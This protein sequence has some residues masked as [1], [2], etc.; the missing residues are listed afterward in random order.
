MSVYFGNELYH[1][2]VKGQHWGE[3]NY[4]NYDGT[5]TAA[6]KARYRNAF[7][8]KALG[9]KALG[10]V[11]SGNARIYEGISRLTGS[12]SAAKDAKN[13]RALQKDINKLSQRFQKEAN[14]KRDA[15]DYGGFKTAK[16]RS[17]IAKSIK[18]I[19]GTAIT[20]AIVNVGIQHF[21]TG[22]IDSSQ[23]VKAAAFS[24]GMSALNEVVGKHWK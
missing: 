11:A 16:R 3:R 6:G 19:S 14:A 9:Y 23:V 10:K 13:Q 24:G 18:N 7:S 8:A 4:Q 5:L 15:I 1:H 21:M 12:K 2:G 17:E 20:S 22:K